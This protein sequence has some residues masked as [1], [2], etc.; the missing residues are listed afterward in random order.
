M[1][2]IGKYWVLRECSS[3][4]HNWEIGYWDGA[5][6]ILDGE[7]GL[8]DSDLLYIGDAVCSDC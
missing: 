4:F 3:F 1:R 7:D 6:W 5:W 2:E 8:K